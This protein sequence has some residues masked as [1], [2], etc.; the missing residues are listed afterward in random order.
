MNALRRV[1]A[2]VLL[3]TTL[4][5]VA[6]AAL[7]SVDATIE[8][9]FADAGASKD[10]ARSM[11]PRPNSAIDGSYSIVVQAG[12]T[13]SIRSVSVRVEPDPSQNVPALGTGSSRSQSYPTGGVYTTSLSMPWDT[14]AVTPYNAVYRIVATLEP[15]VGSPTTATVEKLYVDNPPLMPSG[16]KVRIDAN[17][18]PVLTWTANAEPDLIGYEVFRA[19]ESRPATKIATTGKIYYTDTRAPSG[20]SLTYQLVAVR[21]SPV[22]TSGVRSSFTKS[23]QAVKVFQPDAPADTQSSNVSLAPETTIAPAEQVQAQQTVLPRRD[24][25]AFQTTLPYADAL[26]QRQ[27]PL[28]PSLSVVIAPQSAPA[29]LVQDGV[30]TPKYLAAALLL[31]VGA[32]HLVRAARRLL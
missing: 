22:D 24:L 25:G 32:M 8:F 11:T 4:L 12:A 10:Q 7:A 30:N 26:P 23:S 6:Q 21:N 1:A 20:V 2:I 17:N 27:R 3:A 29:I 19:V 5:C 14:N 15:Q 28:P 16:L 9:K 13:S 31:L 18:R